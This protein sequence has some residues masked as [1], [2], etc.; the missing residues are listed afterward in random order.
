MSPRSFPWA[1]VRRPGLPVFMRFPRRNL[2]TQPLPTLCHHSWLTWQPGLLSPTLGNKKN[3]KV[4]E[5]DDWHPRSWGSPLMREPVTLGS[6]R[7]AIV[8]QAVHICQSIFPSLLDLS[9]VGAMKAKYPPIERSNE[10]KIPD[11]SWGQP[12]YPSLPRVT[13]LRAWCPPFFGSSIMIAT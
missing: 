6:H 13:P 2:W 4:G 3:P 10:R 11:K 1:P 12:S 7:N 5:E 9:L 8:S